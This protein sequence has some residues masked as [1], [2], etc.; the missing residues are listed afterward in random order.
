MDQTTIDLMIS[1]Q[2]AMR[3]DAKDLQS[4]IEEVQKDVSKIAGSIVGQDR[5]VQNMEKLTTRIEDVTLVCQRNVTR[6]EDLE[7]KIGEYGPRIQCLENQK[8][9]VDYKK[10]LAEVGL[11]TITSSPA[12]TFLTFL[13]GAL[14]VGV[15]SPYF[16]D[17]I[18]RFGVSV[19]ISALASLV[20]FLF[21]IWKGRRKVSDVVEK[22][23]GHKIWFP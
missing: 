10:G 2:N 19:A 18:A 23:T 6:N 8:I 20:V 17:L 14:V 12:M 22:G 1:N 4:K 13:I 16:G 9:I 15:Y 7:K 11:K 3:A 5:C 21:L